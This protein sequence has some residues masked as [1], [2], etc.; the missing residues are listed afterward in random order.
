VAYWLA[1]AIF[2]EF[3]RM[4]GADDA[5]VNWQET[6]AAARGRI[7]P[8][9]LILNI[10]SPWAPE[11]PAYNQVSTYFGRP[12]DDI[13][14]MRSDGA[15]TNP[16]WWTAARVAEDE[17]TNPNH[18]TDCLAEFATPEE[19]LFSSALIDD[20]TRKGPERLPPAPGASYVAAMDPATR[21]NGWTLVLVTREADKLRVAL[22]HEWV[23]SRDRPLDPGVV[24]DEVRDLLAPYGVTNIAT[25]QHMGDAL[26]RLGR[27]RGL[28]L[29]QWTLTDAERTRRYLAMRTRFAM[30]HIELPS[31]EH[32]RTD[33]VRVRRRIT[34]TGVSIVLP[35]T[36]DGR[37]CDYAPAMML[38]LAPYL[39]DMRPAPKPEDPEQVRMREQAMKRFGPTRYDDE[40]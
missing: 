2:D 4:A 6:S 12:T 31:V 9:G 19:A 36:S 38:A 40:D 1:S 14:V 34:Q 30:G 11:G 35:L 29:L 33:L 28:S 17:R 15:S 3:P 5:I 23:G 18:R 24:L 32:L 22:A 39:D 21:G 27:D 25:D 13:V 8:G 7:L 16:I 20:A 10:G 26:E 37:H